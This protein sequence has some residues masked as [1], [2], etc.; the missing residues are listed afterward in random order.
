MYI[1]LDIDVLDPAH[2]PGTGNPE[3]GGPTFAELLDLLYAMHS[4]RVVGLDVVEVLP[5]TD[6]GDITAIAAAKLVREA[7]L[8][9]AP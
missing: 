6:Y 9:F 8:L 1:S 7:I 3:P 2:A 4:L 5:A